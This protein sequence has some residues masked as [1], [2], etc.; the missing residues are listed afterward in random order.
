MNLA[1]SI[2]NCWSFINS[3]EDLCWL[4]TFG[5]KEW[6]VSRLKERVTVG[7]S[8]FFNDALCWLLGMARWFVEEQNFWFKLQGS[9]KHRAKIKIKAQK[10]IK[11]NY[12]GS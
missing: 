5:C 2:S 8:K 3:T 4:V 11:L 10:E 9:F 6:E 12:L 1:T 7:G